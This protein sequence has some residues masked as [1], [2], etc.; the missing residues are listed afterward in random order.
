METKS[1][2]VTPDLSDPEKS[3]DVPKYRQ[4][5]FGDEEFAEVKYKVLKWWYVLMPISICYSSVT[6]VYVYQAMRFVYVIAYT[7]SKL[8]FT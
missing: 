8:E 1:F 2:D 5:A 3:L 4:D 6:N 7:C